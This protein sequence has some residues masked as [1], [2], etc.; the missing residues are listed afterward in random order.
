MS[1]V[2]LKFAGATA[3]GTKA[4]V[5]LS[6][7]RMFF[8]EIEIRA[9]GGNELGERQFEFVASDETPD[10]Y[11]DIVRAEGW[12][13]KRYKKNPIVLFNHDS[14]VPVG[15]SPKTYVEGTALNCIVQLADEGTSDFIDTLYKL[16]KQRIVRAMSVGFRPPRTWS[17]C[18]TRTNNFMGLEFNGQELLENSIVSVPANPNS[19]PSPSRGARDSTLNRLAEQDAIVQASIRQRQLDLLRL[20]VSSK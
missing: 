7:E 15:F 12:D 1:K 16:M 4:P 11:G 17:S 18:A 13:L 10:S 20:G 14:D 9:A 19:L 2:Y 3:G 6:G 8:R 5:E